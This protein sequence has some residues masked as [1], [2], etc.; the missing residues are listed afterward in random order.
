MVPYYTISEKAPYADA[1]NARGALWMSII[2][3]FGGLAGILDTSERPPVV[4]VRGG[5]VDGG[6]GG[7]AGACACAVACLRA[8]A[9]GF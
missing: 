5:G 1:F 8:A 7:A 3:G 2:V 6:G 9:R 4:C